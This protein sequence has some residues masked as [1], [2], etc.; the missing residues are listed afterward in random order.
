MAGFGLGNINFGTGSNPDWFGQFGG[1]VATTGQGINESPYGNT[2]GPAIM[3]PGANPY[4]AGGGTPPTSQQAAD[5]AAQTAAQGFPAGSQPTGTG[6]T[7]G[8]PWQSFESI[9]GVQQGGQLSPQM[10][11]AKEAELKAAGIT[12]IK[13]AAG[14]PGKVQFA[15]GAAYDVIQGAGSGQ[16][17]YQRLPLNAAAGGTDGGGQ[18][19]GFGSLNFNSPYQTFNAPSLEDARNSPGYQFALQQ[20]LQGVERSAASKGTLLTGGTLKALEGYGTGLADQTYG[21]LFSRALQS[22]QTNFGNDLQTNQTRTGN[23]YNL[24]ALGKPQ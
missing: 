20:G 23:L 22:N 24:A 7:G 9:L 17:I 4:A 14:L 13:N 2:A 6:A 18:A 11:L 16:N 3:Q 12:L 5:Y 8:D 10:L 21:N 15:N 19:G 1:Q